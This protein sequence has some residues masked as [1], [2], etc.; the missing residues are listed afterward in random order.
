MGAITEWCLRGEAPLAIRADDD[1]FI[2]KLG[3]AVVDV[4]GA[5]W[6]SVFTFYLGTGVV[7]LLVVTQ[8]PC[9][10]ALVI[11]DF[12]SLA[13]KAGAGKVDFKGVGLGDF[14][15]AAD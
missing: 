15:S 13:G 12:N 3:G 5:A 2:V 7:G 1:R 8:R 14:S 9:F 6:F 11:D 10:S 4:N